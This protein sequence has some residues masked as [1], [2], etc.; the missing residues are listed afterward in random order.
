MAVAAL[1]LLA[2]TRPRLRSLSRQQWRA[3]LLLGLALAA[4]NGYFYAS[5]ARI[6][7]G[8]A[9]TVESS[10]RSPWQR[11]PRGE[12]ATSPGWP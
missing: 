10:A 7:L 11:S 6:P 2:V 12:P 5:I 9:V 4:M 3:V 1:V 8:A